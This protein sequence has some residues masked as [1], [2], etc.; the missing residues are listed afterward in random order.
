[1]RTSNASAF[2]HRSITTSTRACAAGDRHDRSMRCRA[3]LRG[4]TVGEC[5]VMKIRVVTQ[6]GPAALLLV[7]LGHTVF[8]V[9]G[10]ILPRIVTGN[11]E[12]CPRAPFQMLHQH[13][14]GAC[15]GWPAR[16]FTEHFLQPVA[17]TWIS[18]INGYNVNRTRCLGRRVTV[19]AHGGSNLVPRLAV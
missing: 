14:A 17:M 18:P 6:S 5:V 8:L 3:S 12:K 9:R 19:N 11:G 7:R 2:I 13:V 1:M 15:V 16:R 10:V 4:N